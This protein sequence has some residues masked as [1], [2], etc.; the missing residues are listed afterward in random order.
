M[1]QA[2]SFEEGT[3]VI[4]FGQRRSTVVD[5]LPR[6]LKVG[7]SNSAA[8]MGTGRGEM[9]RVDVTFEVR[10][11][12]YGIRLFNDKVSKH[13]HHIYVKRNEGEREQYRG[14]T[15]RERERVRGR[16]WQR[17]KVTSVVKLAV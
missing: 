4:L 2:F 11:V 10:T 1:Q 13:G 6:H 3:R 15:E 8:A 17:E 5:C 14:V 9:F 16:A 12:L 7:G